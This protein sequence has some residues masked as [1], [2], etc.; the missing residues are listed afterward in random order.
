M[1]YFKGLLNPEVVQKWLSN[2]DGLGK[3]LRKAQIKSINVNE[4]FVGK[5]SQMIRRYLRG[6]E[7][8]LEIEKVY[9]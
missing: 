6:W 3:G 7:G 5:F 8:S 2:C 1:E 9:L 4:L